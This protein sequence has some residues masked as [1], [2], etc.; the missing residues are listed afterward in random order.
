MTL[1]KI[2]IMVNPEDM[3]RLETLND[4]ISYLTG[5]SLPFLLMANFARIL[6][7]TEGFKKQLIRNGGAMAA[8]FIVFMIFFN[9]Y[10]VASA[11][12]AFSASTFLSTCSCARWS[13][14]S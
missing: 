5:L 13:C 6:N 4:V 8:I 14:F 3:K 1:I 7:N 2:G 11:R 9:R 12:E 10:V